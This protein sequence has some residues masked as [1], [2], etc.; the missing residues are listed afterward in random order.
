M[1]LLDLEALRRTPLVT[2]PFSYVVVPGF[3]P[4]QAAQAMRQD[5]PEIPYPGLLPLEAT[6]P[7]PALTACLAEK[8]GLDLAGRA[9]IVALRSVF[10]RESRNILRAAT[11]R[12]GLR[13]VR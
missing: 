12:R 4:R 2:S 13:C 11:H 10:W 1:A 5:F 9:I 7:G 8:F 6:S 3:V